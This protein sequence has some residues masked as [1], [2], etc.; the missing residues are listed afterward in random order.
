MRK[1]DC[2]HLRQVDPLDFINFLF[3]SA[4]ES[5]SGFTPLPETTI[6][7]IYKTMAYKTLDIRQQRTEIPVIKETNE[8][9]LMMDRLSLLP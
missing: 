9:I 8:V 4:W 6:N 2:K 3:W 7:N 5:K 1:V